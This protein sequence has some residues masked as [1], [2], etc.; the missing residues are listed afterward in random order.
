MLC[1]YAGHQLAIVR[2]HG[3]NA[4]RE[5]GAAAAA[6]HSLPAFQVRA[7]IAITVITFMYE[8]MKPHVVA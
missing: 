3:R 6:E 1:Q 8:S 2:L 5:S 4:E 7:S